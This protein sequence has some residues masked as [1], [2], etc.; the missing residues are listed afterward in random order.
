MEAL[1]GLPD[2]WWWLSLQDNQQGPVH[3]FEGI[4][5]SVFSV[6]LRFTLSFTKKES[7]S[8]LGAGRK[9]VNLVSSFMGVGLEEESSVSH[10][11]LHRCV[12]YFWFQSTPIPSLVL[13]TFCLYSALPESKFPAFL[14]G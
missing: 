14:Q 3:L 7:S 12:L 8:V 5:N 4:P 2:R 13:V 9:G 11:M 10:F 6:L 1:T